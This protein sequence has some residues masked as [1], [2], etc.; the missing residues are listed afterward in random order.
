MNK[1]MNSDAR[2]CDILQEG[3]SP[4]EVKR[5]FNTCATQRVKGFVRTAAGLLKIKVALERG[6]FYYR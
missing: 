2:L 5:N 3:P 1:V 4:P 6:Q